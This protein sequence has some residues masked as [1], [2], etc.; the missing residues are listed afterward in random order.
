[1]GTLSTVYNIGRNLIGGSI[2]LSY[3]NTAQTPDCD[4]IMDPLHH[5]NTT[6]Y[7]MASIAES[8]LNHYIRINMF[9]STC[10]L[11]YNTWTQ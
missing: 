1:M 5:C 4:I 2:I 8:Q 10:R 9:H 11:R 6:Q 7:H 3:V